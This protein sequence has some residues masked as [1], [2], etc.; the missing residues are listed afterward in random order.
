MIPEKDAVPSCGGVRSGDPRDRM[1][2]PGPSSGSR[3]TDQLDV[4]SPKCLGMLFGE[5][6][7]RA[8]YELLICGC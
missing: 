5:N 6:E 7:L 1:Q 8:Y 3:Q 4:T 2:D